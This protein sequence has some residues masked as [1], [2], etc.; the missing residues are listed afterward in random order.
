MAGA[1]LAVRR[2]VAFTRRKA[3]LANAREGH[4]L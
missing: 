2:S 1:C 3:A 4:G